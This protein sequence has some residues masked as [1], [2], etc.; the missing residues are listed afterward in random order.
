MKTKQVHR[1]LSV[2]HL[3]HHFL[4][5]SHWIKVEKNFK[6]RRKNKNIEFRA[7][8]ILPACTIFKHENKR[9]EEKDFF[10]I[11]N[12]FFINFLIS[13]LFAYLFI[14]H[15]WSIYEHFLRIKREL[16]NFSYIV[17]PWFSHVPTHFSFTELI[18]FNILNNITLYNDCSNSLNT[19]FSIIIIDNSITRLKFVNQWTVHF[20]SSLFFLFK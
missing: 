3:F 19:Q 20:Q 11:Y 2:L 16:I 14:Y 4:S 9:R 18:S 12:F 7:S 17:T 6:K 10:L 15:S 8:S 13:I 1:P 5:F